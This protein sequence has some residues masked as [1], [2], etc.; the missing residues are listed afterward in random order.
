MKKKIA[1]SI[2]GSD[3][4]GGA[5]VQADLKAF[6]A[7]DIH[8]VTA[9]TCITAQ[10]TKH[11]KTIYKLPTKLVEEQIDAILDDMHPI[12][13]KTGMLYDKDIVNIVA[14]KIIQYDLKT[15]VDPVMTSTSGD[16]LSKRDLIV[17]TKSKLIPKAYVATPNV[18]EASILTGMEINTP[19]DVKKACKKLYKIGPEY[20]LIK[21][22][23]L[24]GKYVQ[25]TLF[26]GEKFT[27]FSLPRISNKKAH[28]SGCTLSALIT[29]LIALGKSPEEAVGKAKNILW[30]MIYYG[31]IPGMGADVLNHSLDVTKE[32]SS[33]FLDNEHFTTWLE[34]KTSV[35]E[36]VSFL[37]KEYVPEVGLN[38]GY[39]LPNANELKDVCAISGRIVKTKEAIVKCGCIDFGVSKHVA[40]IILAAMHADRS[41]RCAMNIKYSEE[42]LQKC[43]KAGLAISS[44]DRTRESKNVNSTMEWGTGDAIKRYGS[45]PDIIYDKGGIGK[46][47]MIRLLGTNPKEVL[48]KFQ[49]MRKIYK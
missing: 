35:D 44:F 29:G 3:P 14:K 20:V 33:H 30:A 1:L 6:T 2:A 5:G 18:Y 21:G 36:L 31:Y 15:V 17:A 11:V 27:V 34:L 48:S 7:L 46:E 40:S 28:G 12:T 38:M 41:N 8:G 22:G 37:S 49:A 47:P 23:H 32:I 13:A 9:I 4:S 39:A 42:N 10:N 16:V 25:D 43:K 26:D 45:M 19:D 24:E